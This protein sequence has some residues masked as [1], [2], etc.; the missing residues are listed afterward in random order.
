MISQEMDNLTDVIAEQIAADENMTLAFLAGCEFDYEYKDELFTVKTKNPV[1]IVTLP[2][3]SYLVV[4]Q[5]PSGK[6]RQTE[7]RK[8]VW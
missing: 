4:E 7:L 5:L 1:K 6:L 8:N 2:G 3:D